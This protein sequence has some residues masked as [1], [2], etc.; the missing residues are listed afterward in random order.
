MENRFV[1]GHVGRFE[2]QKNH[3]FLIDIFNEIAKEREDA[4]LLLIG[5]GELKEQIT[6][7]VQ[8]Y[9]I[10]NQVQFWGSEKTFRS[11]GMRWMYL[12]FHRSLKACR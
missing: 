3:E 1:V 9:A 10:E 8:E 6:A 7:K 11:Y 4:V 5:D 12:C 2:E